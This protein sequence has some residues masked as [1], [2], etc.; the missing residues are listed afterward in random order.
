MA[1]KN[2]TAEKTILEAEQITKALKEGTEKQLRN[3]MNEALSNLI[4][5]DEN[6]E[7]IEKIYNEAKKEGL[8]LINI[9]I[10]H[11]GTEKAHELYKN[12]EK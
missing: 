11:L 7:E 8:N 5:E 4:K 10:R 9:P 1:K 6:Q 12:I 3:L 2:N